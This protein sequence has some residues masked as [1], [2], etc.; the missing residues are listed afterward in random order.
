MKKECISCSSN[1]RKKRISPAEPVYKGKHW[2]VEHA[3]PCGM[4][5]WLV[6]LPKRHVE[7]LHELRDAENRE[8]GIVF[9]KVIKAL[10]KET[11][12]EKEYIFQIAK[13][14][15]FKHVHFH[16]VSRPKK[17]P[18]KYEGSNIFKL[19]ND[20]K[21]LSKEKIIKFCNNVRERLK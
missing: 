13:A 20:V 5:G 4:V 14:E 16:I 15:G 3:Y 7:S 6:M 8:F 17:L 18:K 10:H 19:K 11:K 2:I 1:S 21:I 12:C 9:P